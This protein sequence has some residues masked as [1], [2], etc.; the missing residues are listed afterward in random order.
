M[1]GDSLCVIGWLTESSKGPWRLPHLVKK[2]FFI[3][4]SLNISFIWIPREA[5]ST[6]D[7]LAKRGV[8]RDF[9]YFGYG[10]NDT[11]I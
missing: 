8:H 4:S 1:E 11:T 2:A 5:N 3:A 9:M 6:G 10:S 7:G